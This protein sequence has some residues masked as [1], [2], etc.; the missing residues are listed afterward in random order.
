MKNILERYLAYLEFTIISLVL[1]SLIFIAVSGLIYRSQGLVPA[2]IAVLM[3]GLIAYIMIGCRHVAREHREFKEK[4]FGNTRLFFFLV[5]EKVL[6]ITDSSRFSSGQR[7]AQ[8]VL[9]KAL[10]V[11]I[12]GLTLG[13]VW[14]SFSISAEIARQKLKE[15]QAII[16]GRPGIPASYFNGTLVIEVVQISAEDNGTPHKVTAII[17]S[18]GYPDFNIENQGVGYETIYQGPNRYIVR[19]EGIKKSIAMFFV[20]QTFN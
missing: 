20:E 18:A 13:V 3:L 12:V 14:T 5:R 1:T 7:L 4:I 16:G 11:I 8:R 19:I 6:G 15:T 17:H 2:A 10:A 9:V